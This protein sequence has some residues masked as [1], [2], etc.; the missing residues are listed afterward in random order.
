MSFNTTIG[1]VIIYCMVKVKSYAKL[2]L[3]LD[4]CGVL[5]NGMHELDMVMQTISIYDVL[6]ITEAQDI[7]VTCDT[8]M[9]P[10]E[11]TLKKA[12]QIFFD[13]T[14][15]RSGIDV[16]IEKNIPAQAGLGGGSSNGAALLLALNDMFDTRLAPG[17]LERMALEIGA[18]APFFIEGG[19]ARA[20]GV[21]ERL[22]SIHNACDFL[23]LLVKPSCG[24]NTKQAYQ[25][26]DVMQKKRV[27][28]GEVVGALLTGDRETYFQYAENALFGAGVELCP[29]V[30]DIIETCKAGG[31][32]FAMM[33]GSGSCVFAVFDT[34]RKRKQ[35]QKRLSEQYPFCVMAENINTI[36]E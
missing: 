17:E 9:L 7:K 6:R 24:V 36:V 34:D 16:Q 25:L 28:T 18:D 30:L 15:I 27:Q 21:G 11:N 31:A 32:Q 12:A 14:E 26:Y 33:S 23:Y 5:P 1:C 20:R 29:E 19:C 13:K 2:N 35:A 3:S 4:I 8:M 10:E 22:E